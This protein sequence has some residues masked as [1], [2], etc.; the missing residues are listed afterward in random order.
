MSQERKQKL[1]QALLN[2]QSRYALPAWT[3]SIA[4][5]AICVVALQA[6]LSTTV[7]SI[8]SALML[9]V[10][11]L[12]LPLVINAAKGDVDVLKGVPYQSLIAVAGVLYGSLGFL[13][14]PTLPFGTQLFIIALP[15][16]VCL[17]AILALGSWLPSFFAFV[18][19]VQIP[20]SVSLVTRGSTSYI[21]LA[22]LS[23]VLFGMGLGLTVRINRQ[24][25]AS[26]ALRFEN[27]QLLKDLAEQNATLAVAR[28]EAQ[29]AC[30]MKDQFLARMSHE[31]RTPMNGVLGMAQ[32]LSNS[33]L[34]E[35]QKNWLN[36]LQSSSDRMMDLINDLLDASSLA[37]GDIVIVES[38]VNIKILADTLKMRYHDRV[39]LK[40]LDF[41][42]RVDENIP[43]S[44]LLDPNRLDQVVT[45]LLGNALKF[46]QTGSIELSIA[47]VA[48]HNDAIEQSS[49]AHSLI[50]TVSDTGVG[51]EP[52]QLAHVSTLFHQA[53]GDTDRSFDGSGLG[54]SI[55]TSLVHLMHGTLC[56][57]S[58]KSEGT[59]VTLTLPAMRSTTPAANEHLP[60]VTSVSRS[61]KQTRVLVAEDNMVNQLVIETMLEELNCVVTLA[62]NGNDAVEYFLEDDF[63]LIFMDCQM[64]VCDGFDATRQ[65]RDAGKKVAIV[66]VTANTMTGDR[67][68]CLDAG[69]NDYLAKP[70]TRSAIAAMLI[71]WADRRD[72]LPDQA[73]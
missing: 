4:F 23:M 30:I 10:M 68:K 17:G 71:R 52:E 55:A 65:L 43:E 16:G 49:T 72:L 22:V 51:I 11:L 18:F 54:L 59:Q 36:A 56:I 67:E 32:L 60:V 50:I 48:G 31:L 38:P 20:F 63:D 45:K 2:V 5:F 6:H 9:L 21:E 69:M 70:F 73:A 58:T 53:E 35:Q 62:D 14:S 57:E 8:W 28:D 40:G 44:L 24:T 29:A 37:N 13:S 42:M 41:V 64:P 34:L 66:A 47:Y 1:D 26:F 39:E 25:R 46:T 19:A 7:L 12:K 33:P 15:M 27:Q 61:G 3:V